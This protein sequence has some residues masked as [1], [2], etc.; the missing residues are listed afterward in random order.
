VFEIRKWQAKQDG[1]KDA[2]C[3]WIPFGRES[4]FTTLQSDKPAKKPP[5]LGPAAELSF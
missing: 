1:S 4:T 5:D 2:M 3:F